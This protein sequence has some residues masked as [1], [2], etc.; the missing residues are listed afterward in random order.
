MPNIRAL[1]NSPIRKNFLANLFGIGVQLLYQIVLVPFYILY[2]GNN[3]YSD[4][5][6]LSAI[7]VIFGM[8]D[9]GINSVIQNRFSIKYA[10]GNLSECNTL[11]SFNFIII[12]IVTSTKYWGCHYLCCD[13]RH[14][15]KPRLASPIPRRCIFNLHT[16]FGQ[17]IPKYVQRHSERNISG[18]TP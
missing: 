6:V 17:H 7:T 5:I 18:E 15:P 11:L 12:S 8:S 14:K 10:E 16:T 13:N 2:W 1:F 4:W 9:I 3:L